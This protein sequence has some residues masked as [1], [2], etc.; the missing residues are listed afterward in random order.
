MAAKER[1]VGIVVSTDARA[2]EEL[3]FMEL[4]VY[5]ARRAGL[6]AKDVANT[7]SLARFRKLL[8]RWVRRPLSRGASRLVRLLLLDPHLI[9]SARWSH[10]RSSRGAVPRPLPRSKASAQSRIPKG[11]TM[12]TQ[13]EPIACEASLEQ[14]Q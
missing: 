5:Q 1:G 8:K 10:H 13:A 11:S 2:S 4:G 6:E 12:P 9:G 14:A 3:G 7:R